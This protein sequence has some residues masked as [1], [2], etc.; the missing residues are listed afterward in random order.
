VR[1]AALGVAG[2][3]A[4]AA[5]AFALYRSGAVQLVRPDP[6]RYP[7][8]GVDV[9]HHQGSIDWTQVAGDGVQFAYLKATEGRDHRDARFA[10]NW[11]GAAAAGPV[12]L[13]VLRPGAGLA[14]L[15]GP[16]R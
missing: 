10:A 6:A 15:G 9:S 3:A 8:R 12:D 16:A 4:V 11:S 7:I 2:L 5:L 1:R 14:E 13:D